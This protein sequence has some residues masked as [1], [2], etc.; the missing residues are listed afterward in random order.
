MQVQAVPIFLSVVKPL[1]ESPRPN[2]NIAVILGCAAL[3]VMGIAFD[4]CESGSATAYICHTQLARS[5]VWLWKKFWSWGA[6]AWVIFGLLFPVG[7]GVAAVERMYLIARVFVSVGCF[8]LVVKTIEY[9]LTERPKKSKSDVI[10]TSGVTLVL[11]STFAWGCF[12]FIDVIEWNHEVVI[13]MTFK[14]PPVI[15]ERQ[16]RHIQWEINKYFLYLKGIGL[17]DLNAQIPSLGLTPIGGPMVIGGPSLGP[18]PTVSIYIPKDAAA[19]DDNIRFAFS[20]YT[21]NR[22]LSWPDMLKPNLSKVESDYDERAAWIMECYFASSFAG[23]MIC[24]NGSPGYQWQ[25]AMWGVR[26]KFGQDY[27]DGIMCYTVNLWRCIPSKYVGD[28]DKFFRYKL[29]SGEGVKGSQNIDDVLKQYG[30]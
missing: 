16:Q 23:Y 3:A 2:S 24:G 22:I 14:Q 10:W 12:W 21:F 20:I 1:A 29:V 8:L 17:D 6:L 27:T 28:F 18:V 7:S 26:T 15:P 25:E 19:N 11:G 13:N 4:L 9:I 5:V 30:L